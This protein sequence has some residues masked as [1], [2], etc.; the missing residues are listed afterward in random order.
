MMSDRV[1]VSIVTPFFKAERFIA[2]TIESVRAQS[3]TNWEWLLIDDASPDGAA[4][5]VAKVAAKDPRLRLIKM[6]K[7]SGPP[8]ARNRA[9]AEV[10]GRFL[11]FLDADDLWLPEKLERQVAFM[12][13]TKAAVSYCMSQ[14]GNHDFSHL[15]R[16][17]PIPAT[18]TYQAHLKNT[19]IVN[20]SSMIDLA[21]TGPIRLDE[22]VHD[23]YRL[24]LD[25]AKKGHSFYGLKLPLVRYRQASGSTSSGKAKQ[26]K[27]FWRVLRQKEQLALPQAFWCFLNY[28]FRATWKRLAY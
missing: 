15:G 20:S 27:E 18:M 3:F 6:E 1:Q 19:P 8:A 24:W 21:Q 11:C 16:P 23:D 14:R 4:Q 7:N 17:V 10:K 12:Q 28:A 5:I 26:A 25:L 22:V 13:E 2:E 9:L